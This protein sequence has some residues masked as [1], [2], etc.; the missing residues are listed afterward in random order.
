[1]TLWYPGF[2]EWER[3]VRLAPR[4]LSVVTGHTRVMADRALEPDLVQCGQALR[5]RPHRRGARGGRCLDQRSFFFWC[6]RP[7][8]PTL[9]WF[10]EEVAIFVT[11]SG[12]CKSIPVTDWRRH[13][14][15]A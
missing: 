12:A 8:R 5:G 1:M 13:A 4:T 9:E 11:G 10:L 7:N 3:K 2:D 6:T 15:R 14:A